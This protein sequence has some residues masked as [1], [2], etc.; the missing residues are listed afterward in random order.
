VIRTIGA[1][2]TTCLDS[3]RRLD[4]AGYA[5]VLSWDHLTGP[6]A[7]KR[8]PEYVEAREDAGRR[9][10]DQLVQ[11]EFNESDWPADTSLE[12]YAAETSASS[13]W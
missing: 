12:A 3:A 7:E 5:G 9:R 1:D 10:S 4:K 6:I 8:L 2:P 13:G 11:G